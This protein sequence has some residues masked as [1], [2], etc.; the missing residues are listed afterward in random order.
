[1]IHEYKYIMLRALYIMAN[2]QLLEIESCFFETILMHFT[3]RNHIDLKCF[4]YNCVVVAFV[5][6]WPTGQ[7]AQ[8]FFLSRNCQLILKASTNKKKIKIL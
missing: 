1:M 4:I 8:I 2:W 6:K 5:N 7:R 3:R